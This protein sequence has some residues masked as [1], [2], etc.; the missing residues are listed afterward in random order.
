MTILGTCVLFLVFPPV[1]GIFATRVRVVDRLRIGLILG[2]EFMP[3]YESSMSFGGP[4]SRFFKPTPTSPRVPLLPWLEQPRRRPEAAFM[5]ESDVT[6][7]TT[8]EGAVM[9][10]NGTEWT[11]RL[12]GDVQSSA[13]S[14]VLAMRALDLGATAWEDAGVL[15]NGT[16]PSPAK[17]Q[18]RGGCV[19]RLTSPLQ[20][21]Y[22]IPRL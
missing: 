4:G 11:I 18:Y 9:T 13:P 7:S 21:L 20:D 10:L 5:V 2:T 19:Q 15:S 1:D 16:C 14:K 17:F 6:P 8:A 12:D 22:H 3:R